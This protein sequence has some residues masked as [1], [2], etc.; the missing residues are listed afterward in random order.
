MGWIS[1]SVANHKK[2]ILL[3]H[4]R[5]Y[6]QAL[7]FLMFPVC[8]NSNAEDFIEAIKGPDAIIVGYIRQFV[9][10]PLSGFLFGTL[11]EY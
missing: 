11:M 5:Y 1:I 2:Q 9:I 6:A 10:K 3:L 7:E 8:V 4:S